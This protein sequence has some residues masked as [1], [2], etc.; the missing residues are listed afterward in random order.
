MY[1]GRPT[2]V[3]HSCSSLW[4]LSPSSVF[5][6]TWLWILHTGEDDVSIFAF[7]Q[8]RGH[9]SGPQFQANGITIAYGQKHIDNFHLKHWANGRASLSLLITHIQIDP[10]WIKAFLAASHL[11]KP[12]SVLIHGNPWSCSHLIGHIL[13]HCQDDS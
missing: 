12:L 3:D 11:K 1:R 6:N 8:T 4:L 7:M 5:G 2:V 9:A 13:R 10:I